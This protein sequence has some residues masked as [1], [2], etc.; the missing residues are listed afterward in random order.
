MEC[1]DKAAKF[2]TKLFPLWVILCALIAYLVPGPFKPMAPA[3]T[4]LLGVVMLGMGLTMSLEDFRLVLQR[5]RDV[6]L[7]VVLRYLIMPLVAFGVSKVLGLPPSLAA[8]LILV[9]CC[10]SGTASNVMTFIAKG[11]TALSVTVS[12]VNTLL[13]PVVTPFIFLWLAGTMIPIN[14]SALLVDIVKVVLAPIAAGVVINMV[15]GGFV[16]RV[17][18]FVPLISVVAIIL[19][20]ATVVALSAAKLATVASIAFIAVILHNTLGL[21]CGYGVARALGMDK[22]KSKAISFE[23]GMENSGLAVALAVAHLDPIAA[24]PG[25]IFSVWHNFSGSMLAGYWGNRAPAEDK[26]P[27]EAPRAAD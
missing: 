4:W 21:S 1:I 2:I 7:G 16:K 17:V 25:A 14:A 26:A 22:R 13:A 20:I 23:I 11:D 6:L 12:S 10:P 9:G 15:A 19:I 27:A 18:R 3:I 5:P 24:I 8:G